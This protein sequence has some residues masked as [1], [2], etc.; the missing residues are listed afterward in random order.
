[1]PAAREKQDP[2]FLTLREFSGA[3]SG[4]NW[5]AY[6]A[7]GA[8]YPRLRPAIVALDASELT[9]EERRQRLTG[10]A[11]REEARAWQPTD[12][13]DSDPALRRF[14]RAVGT[15]Y[16]RW[17]EALW[18]LDPRDP[19]YDARLEQA[20]R[21]VLELFRAGGAAARRLRYR[22]LESNALLLLDIRWRPS[23]G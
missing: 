11:R 8:L 9:E 18:S 12:A 10:L 16:R 20:Y 14:R 5:L 7:V 15:R 4:T 1:M 22:Q 13:D 2:S 21:P 3:L 23:R 17:V 19:D 6:F